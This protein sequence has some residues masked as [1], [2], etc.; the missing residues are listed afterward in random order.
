M[1]EK[2]LVAN[3]GEI[4]RRIM[5]TAKRMGIKTIAIYSEAD[6]NALHRFDADEPARHCER[7]D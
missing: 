4:A 3:R 1:I 2:I 5:R 7:A 6:V